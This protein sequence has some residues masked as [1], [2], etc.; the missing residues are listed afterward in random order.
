MESSNKFKKPIKSILLVSLSNFFKLLSGVLIGFLLPK[1]MDVTEYGFYKTFSLY[2]TYVGLFTI[3]ITD[4]IY[5][6]FGGFNYNDIDKKSFRSITL[7][8]F[9]I[10][11]FFSICFLAVSFFFTGEYRFILIFLSIFLIGNNISVYFQFISQITG[12]FKE[13][14]FRITIQSILNCGSV[15]ILWILHKYTDVSVTFRIYT[16]IYCI[17]NVVLSLWYIFTYRDITFG[18]HLSL[19]NETKAV[20]SLIKLGIPLLIA[21]LCSSLILT[22]DRQ[23]VSIFFSIEEYAIYAFAYNMLS[24]IT[25]TISAISIILYPFLKKQNLDSS[26]NMYSDL[27][28]IIICVLFLSIIVYFPL[29]W[30][31]S[32][33]LPKYISSLPI[34]R[35]ILPGLVISSTI[36]MVFHNYYKIENKEKIYFMITIAILIISIIANLIAY[37]LSKST[38]IISVASIIVTMVWYIVSEV[39]FIKKYKIRWWKNISYIILMMVAFY[40]ITLISKWWLAMII[41]LVCFLVI[42]FIFYRNIIF[43]IIKKGRKTK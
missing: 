23:F 3:G 30:F 32:W 16:I 10:E 8:Y 33:F 29:C 11:T 39:F 25:T 38:L 15:L 34:F 27:S 17:I 28:A 5:L 4:G 18:E 35:V 21:N 14:S 36:S 9:I 1:I 37:Y 13:L 42:S 43:N 2:A 20:W 6:Y 24:L 12:R 19:K 40:S 26:R 41:Y 22:I 31:V 7:L